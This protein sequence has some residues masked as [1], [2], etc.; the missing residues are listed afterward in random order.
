V[1]VEIRIEAFDS[2]AAQ[3]FIAELQTEYL[4]RYGEGDATPVDPAEFAPPRGLFL[5]A[6]LDGVP[7]ACGG[8]RVKGPDAEVKRM[9]VAPSARGRG[10]ARRVLA[11][12]ESTAFAA[13]LDRLI[14]ETGTK[15]PEAVA[16]YQS[17]GYVQIPGFG[18]YRD[19]PNNLCFGKS[20]NVPAPSH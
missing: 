4:R 16:L 2:P 15:Q 5:V 17:A 10:L 14:L 9:Y 20:L 12:L 8:W 1:T 18:H 3:A 7:A 11:E 13:G 6:Y 19:E